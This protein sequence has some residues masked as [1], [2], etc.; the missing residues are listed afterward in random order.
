MA[1]E[2]PSQGFSFDVWIKDLWSK[3]KLLFLLII[4]VIIVYKFRT[5][6]ID[7]L[8]KNAG[9]IMKETEK[10]DK[11]LASQESRANDQANDL[12]KKAQEEGQNKPPI[13]EDWNKRG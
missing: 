13:G 8:V 9:E 7:I 6:I 5:V 2:Q 3:N 12:I 11:D 10:K 1:D 4:P